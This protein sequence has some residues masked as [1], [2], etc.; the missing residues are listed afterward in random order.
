MLQTLRTLVD[1]WC[2]ERVNRLKRCPTS[3]KQ[4]CDFLLSG[5]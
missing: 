2:D 1:G 5:F 4:F 3:T